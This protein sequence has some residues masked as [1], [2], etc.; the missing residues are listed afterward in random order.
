M[1]A[2]LQPQPDEWAHLA[3]HVLP[4]V[5]GNTALLVVG[6][7]AGTLLLGVGLAWLTAVCEFP[8][9]RFFTWALMLPM[10]MPAYVLAFV[11]VALLDYSG[12]VQTLLRTLFGAPLWFPPIRSTWGVVLVMSF[13][14]Y[15]Y[16]YLLAR[17]AFLTQGKRLMEAAQ[18]LGLSHTQA[19]WKVALPM[20]RPWWVAGVTLALMETLADFGTVSIF[21]FD[22]FTTAIYKAWFALFNLP[23]ASQLASLLV[24]LVLFLVALEN[25]AR[26]QRAYAG[27]L[28]AGERILLKGRLRWLALGVCAGVLLMAFIVPFIQ[29]VIWVVSVW[30]TDFDSR[31]LQFI[32]HSVLLASCSALVVGVAALWLAWA[33][34]AHAD[35]ITAALT[36]IATLGYAV[37]GMV[38]AVGIYIPVAWLDQ[39]LAALSWG[40]PIMLGGTLLVMLLG[41]SSRFLAVGFGPIE[42]G[43]KRITDS[44]EEAARSLGLSPRAVLWRLHLPLL[45]GSVLSAALLVFVDVMKEMPITLMTRPFGWDTLSVRI[46]EMTSEGMWEHAALPALFIV[47]V[48]LIPVVMLMRDTHHE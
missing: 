31:Y 12:P 17:Q 44:Q 41:L 33:R 9:R 39:R 16:V 42:A 35:V 37:P 7:G 43:F 48:G 27:R 47:L 6:V 45:S 11:H 5:L 36:R 24:V 1:S 34:R 2:F 14:L 26:G 23:L 21:N 30:Q 29:I 19:F 28:G 32:W 20:S 8:G 3:Q 4:R 22:T 18:T 13:A 10:A 46:F 38:L 25:K 40:V 15:P